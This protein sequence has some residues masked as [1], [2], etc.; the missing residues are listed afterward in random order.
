MNTKHL[1]TALTFTLLVCFGIGTA[2]AQ[3]KGERPQKPPTFEQLIEQ[4]DA[5]EDGQLSKSEVKGPLKEMFEE[6][7]ANEDGF[8]SE[9]EF[10]KMPKPKR[11]GP[12][13]D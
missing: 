1:K 5:N 13:R 8:I 6:A 7:D 12:G 10:Q 4:M 11:K 2:F 3:Q 9:K